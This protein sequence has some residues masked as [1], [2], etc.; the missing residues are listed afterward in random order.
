M[1]YTISLHPVSVTTVPGQDT[2][3][4]VQGS[5]DSVNT[6]FTYQWYLSANSTIQSIA[7]A[8]ETTYLIDPTLGNSGEIFFATVSGSDVSTP[9]L[10]SNRATLTVNEDVTPFDTY[11][12]WPET[13][14]QRHLR[15][16]HLGYI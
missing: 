2:T 13:G 4:T 15:M 8:N 1:A 3:F 14:R 16:R 10:T 5:A 6:T 11:D 9:M 7:G 12:V